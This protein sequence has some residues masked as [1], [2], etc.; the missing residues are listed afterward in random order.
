MS[1]VRRRLIVAVAAARATEDHA[2]MARCHSKLTEAVESQAEKHQEAE[3]AECLAEEHQEAE[4]AEHQ[5]EEHQQAEVHE[6]EESLENL[7]PS[8]GERLHQAN[9][10]R[11]SAQLPQCLQAV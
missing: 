1:V 2:P 9:R 5:A 3:A 6:L 8:Q 7:A 4:A 10:G 11:Q